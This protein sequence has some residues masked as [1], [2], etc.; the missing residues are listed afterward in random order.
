MNRLAIVLALA[1]FAVACNPKSLKQGYCHTTSDCKGAGET[2]NPITR[3]C[4][5]KMDGSAEHAD[6]GDAGPDG[7]DARDASDAADTAPV[8]CRTNEALCADG[9]YDGGPGVCE[10][11]AAV[12][13]EC[14]DDTN[15]AG[16]PTSPICQNHVCRACKADAECPDPKICMTDGHCATSD[17]VVFVEF[18]SSGCPG[19][20]GTASNPYCTPNDGVMHLTSGQNVLVIRGATADRLI[21][22]TSGIAPVVIG[23]N[24][25]SIPAT[26]ATAIQVLS[27]SVL[28]RDLTVTGGTAPGSRGFVASG[29]TTAVKLSNVQ[30]NVGSGLGIQVDS[31]AMLTMDRCTINGN[32]KGGIL[33]DAANFD[34]RNTTITGN[35]PGDDAGAAWGGLRLKNL[36]ATGQK[37]L[38]LLTV[39]NNNNVG[40]SC[41]GSVD[42][43]N[44][45]V[46]GSSGGIDISQTCGFMSCGTAVT[47]T[48][49]AQP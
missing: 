43:T 37:S 19:A 38:E 6:A 23:R 3:K 35:G 7:A 29:A 22:N 14:L 11:D 45:L 9:G 31:G 36:L 13:V 10:P 21:L 25:A 44:V 42:A 30:V 8:T 34:I 27:D 33:I 39:M 48:C 17:E 2:C 26:A 32:N 16:K 20:N 46:A 1:G 41:S 4:E 5:Q 28:I 12:C 49:G 15:C 18:N 24:S 40:V 47:A